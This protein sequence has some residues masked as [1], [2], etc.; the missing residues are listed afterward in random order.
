MD[1]AFLTDEERV[2]KAFRPLVVNPNGE[3]KVLPKCMQ[4]YY[5]PLLVLFSLVVDDKK[6]RYVQWC[7]K[8]GRDIIRPYDAAM[9][10]NRLRPN[11]L[12]QAIMLFFQQFERL[13]I[14][15]TMTPLQ[16]LRHL[17][18]A[19]LDRANIHQ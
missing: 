17:K 12:N 1:L 8:L 2:F 5:V 6:R 15:P 13:N 16:L 11:T 19:Y 9:Q 18:A 4:R 10:L 7:P 3:P 14:Q